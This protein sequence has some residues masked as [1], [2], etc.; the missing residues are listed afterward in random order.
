V[1]DKGDRI[2][3]LDDEHVAVIGER[4]WLAEAPSV[5]ERATD[6]VGPEIAP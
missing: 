1:I 4:G 5:N 6:V 2:E 3:F